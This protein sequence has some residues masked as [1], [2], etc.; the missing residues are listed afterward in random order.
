ML[1][2]VTPIIADLTMFE[3]ISTNTNS[4][5]VSSH[6]ESSSRVS[7]D[8]IFL[9]LTLTKNSPIICPETAKVSVA[10]RLRAIAYLRGSLN[11]PVAA[12]IQILVSRNDLSFISLL[13]TPFPTWSHIALGL[14]HQFEQLSSRVFDFLIAARYF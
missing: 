3:S 11:L 2:C 9:C 6:L 12:Y 14:L 10:T 1:Y 13:T 5:N 4:S 7:G 8:F